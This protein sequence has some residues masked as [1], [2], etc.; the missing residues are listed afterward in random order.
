MVLHRDVDNNA[1]QPML[2]VVNNSVG[3]LPL[4]AITLRYY[5][6]VEGPPPKY[7]LDQLC[8]GR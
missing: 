5:L 4:S 3:T 8:P 2:Q 6:T 7:P 1:V